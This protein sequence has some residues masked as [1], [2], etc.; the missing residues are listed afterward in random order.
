MGFAKSERP[1]M[2]QKS[3]RIFSAHICLPRREVLTADRGTI[4]FTALICALHLPF[5]DNSTM[6]ACSRPPF[7]NF[8]PPVLLLS[9]A[10]FAEQPLAAEWMQS[11]ARPWSP[12]HRSGSGSDSGQRPE[13]GFLSL[14]LTLVWGSCV[15]LGN[16][17]FSGS[18]YFPSSCPEEQQG[19]EDF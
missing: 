19:G 14:R 2:H 3:T 9:C 12:G 8:A 1:L 13:D 17:L 7:F 10:H 4:S 15:R 11:S 6:W 18:R 5:N 16:P